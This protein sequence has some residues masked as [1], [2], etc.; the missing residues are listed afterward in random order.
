MIDQV[1]KQYN[2]YPYP[3]P[4][5]DLKSQIDKGY[6]EESDLKIS[7]PILFPEKKYQENIDIFIAGCGTN[8]AIYHALLYPNSN[9]IYH[10]LMV[11]FLQDMIGHIKISL[12]IFLFAFFLLY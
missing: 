5:D 12:I 8:Q 4:I 2:D 11:L 10:T 9:L 3:E 1:K 7:W 6:R